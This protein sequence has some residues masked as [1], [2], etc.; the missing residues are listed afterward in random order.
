MM[1]QAYQSTHSCVQC[2]V[3]VAWILPCLHWQQRYC[4]CGHEHDEPLNSISQLFVAA[5]AAAG[6]PT[7]GSRP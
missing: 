3:L 4:T 5:A 1:Q 2:G 7:W 6:L